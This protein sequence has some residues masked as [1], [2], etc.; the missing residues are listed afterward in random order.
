MINWGLVNSY[1]ERRGDDC[2]DFGWLRER[3]ALCMRR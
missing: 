1:K 3:R 2:K